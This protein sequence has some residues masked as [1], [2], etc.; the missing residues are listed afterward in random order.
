MERIL[1]VLFILFILIGAFFTVF[2]QSGEP[3]YVEPI[4]EPAPTGNKYLDAFFD[5]HYKLHNYKDPVTDQGYFKEVYSVL[6]PY[7]NLETMIVEAPDYGHE[8][9]SETYSYYFWLEAMYGKYSKNWRPFTYSWLSASRHV[10][11][12]WMDQPQQY[13]ETAA[14]SRV[15]SGKYSPEFLDVTEY[16]IIM[17]QRSDITV[18]GADSNYPIP[19]EKE[20]KEAY[21]GLT[22]QGNELKYVVTGMH[23][24]IDSDN[25]YGFGLRGNPTAVDRHGVLMPSYIHT[26]ERGGAENAWQTIPH[27]CWK[28]REF[29]GEPN[30]FGDIFLNNPYAWSS[31]YNQEYSY[32]VASDADARAVQA[33]YWAQKWWLE[34]FNLW[35][36][37]IG[38]SYP[39]GFDPFRLDQAARM[40]DWLRYAMFDK[41]FAPIGY[42]LSGELTEADP[43]EDVFPDHPAGTTFYDSCH[44]LMGWNYAWGATLNPNPAYNDSSPTGTNPYLGNYP[45]RIGSSNVHWGYQNPMAAFALGYPLSE[46][47]YPDHHYWELGTNHIFKTRST[48]GQNDWQESLA[49]QIEFTRWLQTAEGA[50]GG[51]ATNSWNGR[52]ADPVAEGANPSTFYGLYYQESPVYIG[53]DPV[54]PAD[55]LP[56][57]DSNAWFGWQT[58]SMERFA[59]FYNESTG[60]STFADLRNKTKIIL[61]KWV[62]WIIDNDLIKFNFTDNGTL[63]AIAIPCNLQWDGQPGINWT[64]ST[65]FPGAGDNYNAGYHVLFDPGTIDYTGWTSDVGLIASLARVLIHYAVGIKKE[66]GGTIPAGSVGEQAVQLVQQMLDGLIDNY[67]DDAGYAETVEDSSFA[68]RFFEAEVYVPP[69]I[70]QGYDPTVSPNPNPKVRRQGNLPAGM[71]GTGALDSDATTHFNDIRAFYTSDPKYAE[72]QAAYSSG[73]PVE[74]RYHRFFGQAD[75][76]L[77]FAE[78]AEYFGDYSDADTSQMVIRGISIPVERASEFGLYG[79]DYLDV[80]DRVR[81]YNNNESAYS[82]VGGGEYQNN[83]GT[84]SVILGSNAIVNNVVVGGYKTLT[85]RDPEIKGNIYIRTKFYSYQ[86]DKIRIDG[87]ILDNLGDDPDIGTFEIDA[88]RND[89]ITNTDNRTVNDNGT[90]DLPPGTYGNVEVRNNATL[91]LS[92]GYYDVNSFTTLPDATINCN[93]TNGPVVLSIL[94]NTRFDSRVEITGDPA[95]ILIISGTYDGLYIGPQVIWKGT[96]I[97]PFVQGS[98]L[99]NVDIGSSG[100]VYGAII[101]SSITVHQDTR[102]HHVPFDYDSIND[103]PGETYTLT[104]TSGTGSGDYEEDELINISW[105][106]PTVGPDQEAVFI[107][108]TGDTSYVADVNS[109]NTTVTMPAQNISI[110]ADFEINSTIPDTYTLTV[111]GGTGSGTYEASDVVNISWTP[112]SVGPNEEAVFIQWTGDTSYVANVNNPTTTVTMPAQNVSLTAEYE[113]NTIVP[114]ITLTGSDYGATQSVDGEVTFIVPNPANGTIQIENL[115]PYGSNVM[116]S[117]NGGTPQSLPQLWGGPFSNLPANS[118]ITIISTEPVTFKLTWW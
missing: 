65:I 75:I 67:Q 76:A 32:T 31:G 50:I 100:S 56:W 23:W 61:D 55:D 107:Q 36:N 81:V 68:T 1:K 2:S 116:V 46:G 71:G 114:T 84:P 106:P 49:R 48:N 21:L 5:L 44:Y 13:T 30:G 73:D 41:Y 98:N 96:L 105:I 80:H 90:M 58:W 117:I 99:I 19:L 93:T 62:G 83:G 22:D 57:G 63:R 16:P 18:K 89:F 86:N 9:T 54:N 118:S 25:V 51:G 102:I 53:K 27:P 47:Q 40:G 111:T 72:V 34:D 10:I 17:S 104:V 37:S 94:N 7:H 82:H 3:R 28:N 70:P 33:M 4:P 101:G 64:D 52:Y 43:M 78:F 79:T 85:L 11:P 42:K 108:W 38:S 113:I 92:T 97:A 110:E 74:F 95:K 8:T 112:P 60:N 20:L 24:I 103:I 87:Y 29:G 66:N 39:A 77:A 91:N 69:V 6:V 15:E 88:D 59:E 109:A 45:W 115:N 14:N 12:N 26:C 35:Q